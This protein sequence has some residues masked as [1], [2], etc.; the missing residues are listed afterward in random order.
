MLSILLIYFVYSLSPPLK[1]N[2]QELLSMLHIQN[3][4]ECMAHVQFSSDQSLSR[5][6]LFSTPWIAARQASLS[7]NISRSSLR[8]PL[9]R[10]CHPAISSSVVPF[11][12]CPQSLPASESLPMTDNQLEAANLRFNLPGWAN[13]VTGYYILVIWTMRYC[14]CVV[15]EAIRSDQS[16]SRVRLFVT[17][18]IAARQASLS[19]TNRFNRKKKKKKEASLWSNGFKEISVYLEIRFKCREVRACMLVF[20]EELIRERSEGVLE[21]VSGNHPHWT[22]VQSARKV[23]WFV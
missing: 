9:S 13:A 11:S 23:E 16:L 17:P 4:K 2:F 20:T 18:W 12:S 14:T 8:R 22:D 10:W 19:I 3:L 15:S 1:C 5:V 6:R 7:I 21:Q